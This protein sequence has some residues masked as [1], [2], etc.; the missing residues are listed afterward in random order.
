MAVIVWLRNCYRL[1]DMTILHEAVKKQLPV[2][3][4]VILNAK[5]NWP[6]GGASKWWLH[7]S[8]DAF[9]S[10]LEKIGS[11]LIV[12]QGQPVDVLLKLASQVDASA[13]FY[14]HCYEPEERDIETR[15]EAALHPVLSVQGFHTNVLV[16][17]SQISNQHGKPYQ[18]FTPFWKN[19]LKTTTIAPPLPPVEW[20]PSPDNWPESIPLKSFNLLPQKPNW[21][22][23][24]P[25]YWQPGEWG[26]LEKLNA[27]LSDP[28][29]HYDI[30]RDFPGKTGTSGISAHLHF[31][32]ISPRQL[33]HAV[34]SCK[35]AFNHATDATFSALTQDAKRYL[36]EI[37]W[38][39]FGY[40]L[41]FH[42]PETP[43]KPL[44]AQFE[45][46]PWKVNASHLKQWQSG[47][48]GYPIVDAGMRQLWQTGWMH[49]RVRMIVASFLV[50]HLLQPWQ[51][52]AAWF[53]DTLVDADLASNTL[54]WQWAGGCGADAAPYFRIFNPILQSRK[55]DP[56]GTYIRQWV[57]EVAKLP[58]HKIH[59]P[60]EA[61]PALLRAAGIGLNKTYPPPIVEHQ[62]ARNRALEAFN[63][64]KT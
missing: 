47:E 10:D 43:E 21:A 54:G 7:H 36:S 59:A 55:F 63:I 28:V 15:V 29:Q 16:P 58:D 20:L 57:P 42:F 23:K 14:N 53:W 27:F 35:S 48:T 39:D 4:V 64:V 26:A 41:L 1:S 33:W 30:N 32:E 50:K 37:G 38:R 12:Q 61:T 19:L 34:F 9:S 60:W 52:G 17:P 31:G 62:W 40:Q 6:L 3:P 46:F 24:F 13:L 45:K 51:D 44:R 49:N 8:L 2:V 22:V 11:K 25:E 18:V 5:S 56:M